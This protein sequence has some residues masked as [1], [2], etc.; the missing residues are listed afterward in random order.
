MVF[1]NIIII[2]INIIIINIII[3]III[4]VLESVFTVSTFLLLSLAL[5]LLW[6][7]KDPNEIEAFDYSAQECRT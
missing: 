1:I 5:W 4:R 6:A 7:I 2:K 3:I